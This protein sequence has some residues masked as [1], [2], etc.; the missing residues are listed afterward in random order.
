M[1]SHFV[2]QVGKNDEKLVSQTFSERRSDSPRANGGQAREKL[3][4]DKATHNKT[5][6]P[7]PASLLIWGYPLENSSCE[8]ENH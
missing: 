1:L 8:Y 4:R 6:N 2:A 3:F 5:K 7:I